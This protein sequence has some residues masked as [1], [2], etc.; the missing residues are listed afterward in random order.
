MMRRKEQVGRPGDL[1]QLVSSSEILLRVGA[2]ARD[3]QLRR[4]FNAMTK[5]HEMRYRLQRW[6]CLSVRASVSTS[7]L[8]E[9]V[10]VCE[11]MEKGPAR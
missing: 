7:W 6:Q 2:H 10:Q 8:V 5:S 1:R 4:T 11:M 9:S 3:A